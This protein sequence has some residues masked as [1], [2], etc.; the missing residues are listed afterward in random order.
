MHHHILNPIDSEGRVGR[1][2]NSYLCGLCSL[3][4]V[5]VPH[6]LSMAA[7]RALVDADA[8]NGTEYVAEMGAMLY[9]L[10]TLA[11]SLHQLAACLLG[12]Q[13]E[14]E[15]FMGEGANM[16][17]YA[18][19]KQDEATRVAAPRKKPSSWQAN[20]QSL[21][22]FQ[23]P[24]VLAR[25]FAG[26]PGGGERIGTSR[27]VDFSYYSDLLRNG[28]TFDLRDPGQPAT[29]A[30]LTTRRPDE[31]LGLLVE[32]PN[33]RWEGYDVSLSGPEAAAEFEA[34]LHQCREAADL[35]HGLAPDDAAGY[36][37][38]FE[39]LTT[40]VDGEPS[41]PSADKLD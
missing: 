7:H 23:L 27:P 5:V 37:R 21:A 16:D 40:I 41:D 17:Q 20:P 30:N 33:E 12:A 29:P 9:H 15:T 34:L 2:F 28:L 3:E 24:T 8:A 26:G 11:T 39:L 25:Y 6:R 13:E 1:V 19:A 14:L 38:L 18:R 22:P 35:Y 36:S 32:Q 4:Q 31:S 10:T